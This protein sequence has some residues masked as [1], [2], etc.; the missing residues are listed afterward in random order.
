MIDKQKAIKPC[1]ICKGTGYEICDNPDHGFIDTVD[2]EIRRL[3][4]PCCGHD[5]QHRI[6]S[7]PCST[8]GGTKKKTHYD[9]FGKKMT[10]CVELC[11]DCQSQE[12]ASYCMSCGR[13][14]QDLDDGSQCPKCM[15]QSQESKKYLTGQEVIAGIAKA[16]IEEKYGSVANAIIEKCKPQ[17]QEPER[18]ARCKQHRG[19]K[20]QS[21]ESMSCLT[22]QALV[23]CEDARGG[24]EYCD[25][26]KPKSS[27][28]PL[29]EE[30]QLRD[31]L[32][33][34]HRDGGHHTEKVGL[35]QSVK[36][37]RDIINKYKT[38]D[39]EK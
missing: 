3:G 2:G 39:K 6:L 14:T 30:R 7:S 28:H 35:R 20:P 34:I 13:V 18:K 32:A 16:Q 21:Q 31:L 8:C 38:E 37:A 24:V 25:A 5:E 33:L 36:D 27:E 22:C 15:P 23:G 1:P 26:Y 12:Q 9:R 4:C 11:P 10:S 29:K 19:T 17:S